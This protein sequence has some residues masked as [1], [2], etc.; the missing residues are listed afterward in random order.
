GLAGFSR[1]RDLPGL[2]SSGT[3]YALAGLQ[4][5]RR[6]NIVQ[7]VALALGFMAILLLTVTRGELL[8]AWRQATPADAPNRFVINIQPDQAA[9]V[10]TLFAG[11]GLTAELSPMVRA[12]LMRVNGR[13]VAAADFT[14]ERAQRLVEREFNLSWRA[15]L[16]DGNRIT[17]G[18]WFDA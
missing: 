17:A 8:D 5:H 12:R 11:A 6:S 3:R 2:E 13:A 18:K 16:P 15:D 14:E 9:E 1:L 7:I 4:R 10:Q